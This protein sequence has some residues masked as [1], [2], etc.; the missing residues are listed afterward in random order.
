[1]AY[2]SAVNAGPIPERFVDKE[3]ESRTVRVYSTARFSNVPDFARLLRSAVPDFSI[4]DCVAIWRTEHAGQVYLTL[5]SRDLADKFVN[6]KCV[7]HGQDKFY[8]YEYGKFMVSLRVHWL[9]ATVTS[10]FLKD[11]F[12]QYG[13]VVDAFRE[14]VDIDGV[15]VFTGVRIVKMELTDSQKSAIPHI[16]RFGEK[17]SMLVTAPG[18][19]PICLRCHSVGHV[20]AKCPNLGDVPEVKAEVNKEPEL[21]DDDSEDMITVS[22][23]EDGHSEDS[24]GASEKEISVPRVTETPAKQMKRSSKKS[25]KKS[26]VKKQCV[27]P[28]L[29]WAE[30]TSQDEALARMDIPLPSPVN[31]WPVELQTVYKKDA[32]LKEVDP[33]GKDWNRTFTFNISRNEKGFVVFMAQPQEFKLFKDKLNAQQRNRVVYLVREFVDRLKKAWAQLEIGDHEFENFTVSSTDC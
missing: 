21:S 20:R 16:V 23:D 28:G 25:P 6:L 14:F 17:Q 32:E 8:F 11:Y 19:L 26:S 33:L 12:S 31:Q 1:M 24:S 10:D 15:N 13:R 22:D 2:T 4:A 9:H 3:V 5:K 27:S 18:R 29:S 30:Q 7:V